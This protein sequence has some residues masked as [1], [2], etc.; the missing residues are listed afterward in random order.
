MYLLNLLLYQLYY[1]PDDYTEANNLAEQHPGKLEIL[2][3]KLLKECK[4]EVAPKEP[5]LPR[6][7]L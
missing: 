6:I 7:K 3:E 2:K 5:R 1:L 4:G